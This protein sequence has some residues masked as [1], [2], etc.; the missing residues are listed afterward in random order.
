MLG[1]ALTRTLAIA[2]KELRQLR[3]DRLSFGMIVGIPLLQ[4]TL[5]GYAIN[6]DVRHLPAAVVDYAN[7]Q[8]ARDLVADA[9]ATQV[10]DIIDSA[11]SPAELETMLERGEIAV[12]LFIPPDFDRRLQDRNRPA[13]QLLVDG[14]DPT[15]EGVAR[16]LAQLPIAGRSPPDIETSTLFAVRTY[17][18]PERRSAVQIVPALIGVILNLT[19]VL[20]TAIAIVRERERGNLELL[21][22]TPVRTA[23]LMIGKITPYVIIGLVQASL[24]LL[25]GLWWF[26][27]PVRGS[28][29][30]LYVAISLF[31]AA[32]LAL[33]L[34]I[35]TFAKTQ[36]QA[37][38]LSV[39]I[40]L[41]SILL[42]GF[43]FPFAGMPYFAQW[44]AELFPLTH[45]VRLVRGILLR[46]AHLSE[47]LPEAFALVVFFVVMMSVAIM[48]FRKRLD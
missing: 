13:A 12:G 30:E 35:S 26:D 44:L 31:I 10:I 24:I 16:Q 42:S 32:S 25:V 46:G 41:P 43:M 22:T 21:I 18:N 29:A 5:F 6:L 4:I 34:V 37:M 9:A 40:Y 39:F 15:I 28:M 48:R 45:C 2:G 19:M 33:G 36:F 38:Q 3:R 1:A 20:F 11:S 8:R 17:Y 14:S 47:L 23:E 27:V 7:T